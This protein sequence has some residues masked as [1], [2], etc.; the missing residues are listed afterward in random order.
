MNKKIT[1][2]DIKELILN[3]HQNDI[4]LLE[5][6]T[7]ASIHRGMRKFDAWV[8]KPTWSP[9]TTIGY[10][11]KVSRND[12]LQDKK[13]PSYL[14]YCH[15]LYFVTTGKDIID[16]SELPDHVG[17][18]Y[19]SKNCARWITKKKAVHRSI[20]IPTDIFGYIL[21]SRIKEYK[22]KSSSE[23]S[24][25][26]K[27]FEERKKYW[28]E[29]IK[30]KKMRKYYGKT[31]PGK[32]NE[33]LHDTLVDLQDKNK[34]IKIENERLQEVKKLMDE[35][36]ISSARWNLRETLENKLYEIETGVGKNLINLVDSLECKFSDISR[37]LKRKIKRL[38]Q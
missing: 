30:E 37:I 33:K 1:A 15:K 9:F 16:K 17:L 18:K 20:T 38:D 8:M 7:G 32:V 28:D 31:L 4:A 24:F 25:G 5:C 29:W 10:E 34:K 6:K 23:Y 26:K 36:G 22:R 2:N 14:D 11:I 13:W 3:S 27:T 35:M 21:M 12:F 19:V